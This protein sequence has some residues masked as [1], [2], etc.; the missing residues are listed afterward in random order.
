MLAAPATPMTPVASAPPSDAEPGSQDANGDTRGCR[1]G[2]GRRAWLPS[3][4]TTRRRAGPR[5]PARRARRAG[6]EPGRG[7]PDHVGASARLAGGPLGADGRPGAGPVPGAEPSDGG[8]ATIPPR[9]KS[10]WGIRWIMMQARRAG[11]ASS[12]GCSTISCGGSA[13][14]QGRHLVPGRHRARRVGDARARRRGA[15][16]RAG[17]R[18]PVAGPRRRTAFRRRRGPADDHRDGI[19]IP[20]RR[21][22]G[23][24]HVPRRHRRARLPTSA[25]SPTRWPSWSAG[26]AS[27]SGST[28]ARP[29]SAA[30][31]KS[32]MPSN[33]ERWLDAEAGPVVRPYALTQGR[34]RHTG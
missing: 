4:G 3:S 10:T 27:T 20:A 29:R 16:G 9:T 15:P 31:R 1:A 28:R 17:G 23:Q 6:S 7:P 34:T 32:A 22:R 12:T 18:V 26:P 19:G 24:R 2:S 21:R 5:W 14:E 30:G 33:D 11:S 8:G 25:W 13:R